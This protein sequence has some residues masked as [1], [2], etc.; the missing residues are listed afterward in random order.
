MNV[1]GMVTTLL[2]LGIPGWIL[3][4]GTSAE[5]GEADPASED[6]SVFFFE[7]FEDEGYRDR[8]TN[9]SHLHNHTLVTEDVFAGNQS[10]QL[11]VPEGSHTGASLIFKFVD[12]E[13]EE[14]EELYAR[15]CLK[16]GPNWDPG[17]GG[18]LPGPSGTYGRAGWG[19][20]PV[21]G[22]KGWSAR[23]GFKRSGEIPGATKLT[24]YTYHADMKGKYGDMLE[25]SIDVENGKWVSI[26]T[27]VKMN[28]PGKNDGVLRG[29]VDGELAYENTGLRFRDVPE[30]KVEQFWM[31]LYYG[32][33]WTPEH[34]MRVYL[35]N[36]ALSTAPIPEPNRK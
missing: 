2:L 11:L 23:M 18:K 3:L 13:M 36:V 30:L 1:A 12:A 17:R 24:Y 5:A 27:Y 8:F 16:F 35:D 7:G 9:V 14:P 10:L 25:W 22:T 34:D 19:G 6:P 26:Q 33:S 31:N 20:R 15:Y 32:G 29:W 28:T 21:S 4:G